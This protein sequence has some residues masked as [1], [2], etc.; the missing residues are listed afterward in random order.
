MKKPVVAYICGY[1]A[2][3]EKPMGHAGA[4]QSRHS[5][6]AEAKIEALSANGAKTVK[7]RAEIFDVV[8]TII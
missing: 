5:D 7:T 4:I 8:K 2:P 1:Y 6:T 3:K